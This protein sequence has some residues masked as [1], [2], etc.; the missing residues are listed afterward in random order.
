MKITSTILEQELRESGFQNGLWSPFLIGLWVG[1]TFFDSQFLFH[2]TSIWHQAGLSRGL[3]D[4]QNLLQT[5]DRHTAVFIELLPQLKI[6][7][8]TI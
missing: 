4:F 3:V 1:N 2:C 8:A 6:G 5:E 7:Q